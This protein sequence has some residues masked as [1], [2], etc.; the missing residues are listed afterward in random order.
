MFFVT[1][2]KNILNIQNEYIVHWLI[3]QEFRE[4]A[5]RFINSEKI[6]NVVRHTFCVI[7][8]KVDALHFSRIIFCKP[9]TSLN[10]A[11]SNQKKIF[12]Q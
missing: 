12:V 1:L 9:L 7:Y 2:I 5:R 6:L 3:A 11:M 4:D 8:H 10:T